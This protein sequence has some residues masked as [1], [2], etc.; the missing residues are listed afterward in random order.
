[1]IVIRHFLS[2]FTLLLVVSIAPFCQG[3]VINELDAITSENPQFVEL[4]GSPNTGLE[5]T[6]AP[7][8][9]IR[10]LHFDVAERWHV[11]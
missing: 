8:L 4:Y 2:V 3:V 5:G 9:K 7:L 11:R 6:H 10:I 1:M